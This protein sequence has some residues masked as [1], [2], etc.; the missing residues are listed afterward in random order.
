MLGMRA[1]SESTIP[2]HYITILHMNLKYDVGVL[3]TAHLEKVCRYF[4]L[5]CTACL[6][7]TLEVMCILKYSVQISVFL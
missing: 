3:R 7:N 6:R 1:E 5:I 2:V 4:M